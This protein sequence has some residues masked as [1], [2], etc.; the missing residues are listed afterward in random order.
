[1]QK[2]TFSPTFFTPPKV[3]SR[4][5]ANINAALSGGVQPPKRSSLGDNN[6]TRINPRNPQASTTTITDQRMSR[7]NFDAKKV[8][9]KDGTWVDFG[10]PIWK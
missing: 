3:I 4:E 2:P 10:T 8:Q 7:I 9:T 1:M 6:S 5:T